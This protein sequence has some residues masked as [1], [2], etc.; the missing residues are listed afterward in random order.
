[1]TSSSLMEPTV[2]HTVPEWNRLREKEEGPAEGRGP[3]DRLPGARRSWH[4][5]LLGVRWGGEVG[6]RGGG[7]GA[8]LC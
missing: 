8:R 2:Y 7:G 4:R 6:G 5:P 1:M 3:P